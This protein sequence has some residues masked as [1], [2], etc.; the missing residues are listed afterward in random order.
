MKKESVERLAVSIPVLVTNPKNL[1]EVFETVKT[2]GRITKQ[3][4]RAE[5]MVRSLKKRADRDH[6]G[7]FALV[8]AQGFF[9]DQRTSFDHRGQRHFS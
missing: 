8:P 1:N 6:S 7:L 5:I 3:E 9:A 2:I 4:N